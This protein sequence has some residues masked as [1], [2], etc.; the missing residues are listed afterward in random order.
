MRSGLG[1]PLKR[2][3]EIDCVCPR[4]KVVIDEQEKSV[5]VIGIISGVKV[6]VVNAGEPVPENAYVPIRWSILAVWRREAADAGKTFEQRIQLFLPNGESAFDLLSPSF[7]MTGLDQRV[8][9]DIKGL[10]V[11]VPGIYRLV[12]S[13]REAGAPAW[14]EKSDFEILI[15]HQPVQMSGG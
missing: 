11:S 12:V 1:R 15:E 2:H 9:S 8:R 4:Q 14:I 13:L 6:Q 10:G 5:S 7:E 3:A